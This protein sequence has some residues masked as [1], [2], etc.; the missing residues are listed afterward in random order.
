MF[1]KSSILAAIFVLLSMGNAIAS[2]ASE[3][4]AAD[5]SNTENTIA[6][7]QS[8]LI[9]NAPNIKAA[10]TN[11]SASIAKARLLKVPTTDTKTATE[12]NVSTDKNSASIAK[13]RLRNLSTKESTAPDSL[14]VTRS[15]EMPAKLSISKD[16]SASIAP[17]APKAIAQKNI[18]DQI[19]NTVHTI[20]N[21][22]TAVNTIN[23]DSKNNHP[24]LNG[25]PTISNDFTEQ[26]KIAD[27]SSEINAIKQW[28]INKSVTLND[29][30]LT[31]SPAPT[32]AQAPERLPDSPIPSAVVETAKPVIVPPAPTAI[33][34]P[35]TPAIGTKTPVVAKPTTPTLG[36]QKPITT[37][38]EIKKTPITVGGAS[39][40]IAKPTDPVI[41]TKKPESSKPA[42]QTIQAQKPEAQNNE[43]K[44]W[45]VGVHTQ[46]ST[47]GFVGVDAGYKFSPNLHT[48]LGINTIGFNVDYTSQG[49]DYKASL[50]PTNVHLLGD[51]FPFGGGLR[52]TGGLV[53]QSN[54]FNATGTPNS[55]AI[56]GG[57]PTQINLG[58]TTYNVSDVGTVSSEGSFSNSVAPYL[59]IGFGT[60]LSPG[61]GFN[62]DAGVM[63]AGSANV[64]LRANIPS[65][66]PAAL[67]SQIRTSLAEQERKTNSDIGSFNVYPVI[68]VGISY[69]F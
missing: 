11:N 51:F 26:R 40:T 2:G 5:L 6:E 55:S 22:T 30:L 56:P 67:Q 59:G 43:P 38:T 7:Q 16:A 9:V 63:F 12:L 66:V 47:T 37:I 45:A 1:Y 19:K 62:F 69:A 10:T 29:V 3:A 4:I 20:P 14:A 27:A 65:T 46:L 35:T 49:I 24:E 42:P 60:P 13:A 36:T 57:I 53:F 61:L 8:E 25:I 28:K 52:L 17:F 39:E 21:A 68:S 44:K 23:N 15:S 32:I 50:S 33:A 18:K 31:P 34:K 54:Q 58:G 41:E 48:R 64:K